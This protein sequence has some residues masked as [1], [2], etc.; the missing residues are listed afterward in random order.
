M[1][2]S[3]GVADGMDQPVSGV[4]E[5]RGESGRRSCSRDPRRRAQSSQCEA[6]AAAAAAEAECVSFGP[7]AATAATAESGA[8][9][10]DA[11]ISF[12]LFS[13]VYAVAIHDF[14]IPVSSRPSAAV[15]EAEKEKVAAFVRRLWC[16]SES[17]A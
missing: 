6:T 12:S 15:S 9:S 4:R 11:V 14:L 3:C 16:D 10:F 8:E 13:C 7:F 2:M 17:V 1:S 5:V